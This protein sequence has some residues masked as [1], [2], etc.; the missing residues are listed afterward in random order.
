MAFYELNSM[1]ILVRSYHD[2]YRASA[3]RY[4]TYF[5]AF[6]DQSVPDTANPAEL[7]ESDA[8]S[9]I[10]EIIIAT[11][12]AIAHNVIQIDDM[13]DFLRLRLQKIISNP[14]NLDAQVI[15]SGRAIAILSNEVAQN[16]GIDVE[17]WASY[18]EKIKAKNISTTM[19]P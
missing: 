13:E 5:H 17:V 8:D 1:A 4:R 2:G 9:R 12:N 19:Q 18:C 3:E 10:K 15:Q 6:S 11:V 14:V 7:L 16:L